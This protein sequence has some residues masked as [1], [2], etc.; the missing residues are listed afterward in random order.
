MRRAVIFLIRCYQVTLSGLLGMNCRFYPSCSSYAIEAIDRYGLF[1]GL[2]L[3]MRRVCRCNPWH[4]G[5]LDPVPPARGE[6]RRRKAM[7]A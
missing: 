7:G 4:P 5:G 2:F 1:Y 6:N 3:S